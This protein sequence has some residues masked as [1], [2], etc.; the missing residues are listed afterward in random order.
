MVSGAGRQIRGRLAS[1]S[2]VESSWDGFP[3]FCWPRRVA[4][5]LR[6]GELWVWVHRQGEI[7]LW[8]CQLSCQHLGNESRSQGSC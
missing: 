4:P 2:S 1:S 5:G 6:Y 8:L 3:G 7:D